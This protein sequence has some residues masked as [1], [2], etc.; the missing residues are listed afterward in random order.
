M[1][2]IRRQHAAASAGLWDDNPG[3]GGFRREGRRGER[4]EQE[5]KE[6]RGRRRAAGGGGR[7]SGSVL[8]DG[9]RVREENSRTNKNVEYTFG[10]DV[11]HQS[12]S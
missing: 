3:R 4:R 12:L 7:G 9:V 11:S 5:K 1:P 10:G 6:E 8:P 2:S